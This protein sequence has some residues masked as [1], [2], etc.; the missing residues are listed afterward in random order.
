M[1]LANF[2]H[3]SLLAP[4]RARNA[5]IKEKESRAFVAYNRGI[6]SFSASRTDGMVSQSE[7]KTRNLLKL[8]KAIRGT[9]TAN[10]ARM[11]IC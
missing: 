2:L 3:L 8:C 4:V 10:N 11:L 9:R 1:T 7:I 6:L 5:R